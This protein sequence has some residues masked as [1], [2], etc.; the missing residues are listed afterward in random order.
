MPWLPNYPETNWGG[1]PSLNAAPIAGVAQIIAAQRLAQQKQLQ[2]GMQGIAKAI[3]QQHLEKVANALTQQYGQEGLI[4]QELT[5]QGTAGLGAATDYIK[6]QQY[7]TYP[8]Q[9]GGKEYPLT[10]DQ[11]IRLAI[12]AQV[13]GRGQAGGVDQSQSGV[14]P[15]PGGSGM[16]G[17]YGSTGRWRP[18]PG[19]AQGSAAQGKG[20]AAPANKLLLEEQKSLIARQNMLTKLSD[21][22][23]ERNVKAMAPGVPFSEAEEYNR[24]KA[25]LAEISGL[26]RG[27]PAADQ[28]TAQGYGVPTQGGPAVG[29]RRTINGKLAEWDGTGWVAV[30]Q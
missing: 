18:L 4:P 6:A 11:R 15:D 26:L 14:V 8:T 16:L 9:I 30:E 20:G 5:G 2:E 24:N 3:Q 25:R 12:A 7:R 17:I 10:Q 13:H 1:P 28:N 23:R 27:K 21:L 29:T 19:W 22:E